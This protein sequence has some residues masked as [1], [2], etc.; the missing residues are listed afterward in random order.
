MP[1]T[2]SASKHSYNLRPRKPSLPSNHPFKVF[3]RAADRAKAAKKKEFE[4][5]GRSYEEGEW[6]NG[7]KIW[8][9]VD[10]PKKKKSPRRA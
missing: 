8:R 10:S 6:D 4:H 1:V 3:K 7:V 5:K 9:R 2:R